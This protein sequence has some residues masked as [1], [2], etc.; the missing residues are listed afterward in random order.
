MLTNWYV[1]DVLVAALL[2]LLFGAGRALARREYWRAA[3]RQVFRRRLVRGAFAVLCVYTVI[4]LLDSVGWH[5]PLR[6]PDGTLRRQPETRRIMTDPDG[7]SVLDALLTPLREAREKTYS[8]PLAVRQF[9]RETRVDAEGRI[10]RDHP[11]LRYPR[12][13]LLGTD[14]VG[15]DVLY[16][17]LKGIRTGMIIGAFTTLL[18][19]PLA[20][21]FG[22]A[23]G[24][25]G[26]WIDDV[27]QYVYTVLA[28][29]PAVLLIAAF[30][31]IFGQGLP[32]LCVILGV[33]SWTGLCRVLRGET[34]KLREQEF[35]QAAEA[36][37]VSRARIM[38]R[39][40]VPNVMHVVLITAVLSFS[41]RVLAEAVLTYIGI[42]VGIDTI[43]WG[44]M[45]ND[46]LRE[47]ARS[48]VI[49][50][51]V[52]AALIFMVGLVL[53]ANIFGDALR[54]ALDPRL[55]ME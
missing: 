40:I 11:P 10:V 16:L 42:G 4:A 20:L 14:R 30:M 3:L 50:W 17:A 39:H 9:T 44:V 22:V 24:Y 1:Q 43:S 23:A 5:P 27:I 32:Q 38:H 8:A 26:G 7:L 29:I 18:V 48:P 19:I 31:V 47:L 2:L 15:H 54:D 34:M 52:A 12:R 35:V 45:I 49:W 41:G 33:T 46:A 28:S 53:P 6:D 13:H 25:L 37:G 21:F 51:K 55:R 36:T